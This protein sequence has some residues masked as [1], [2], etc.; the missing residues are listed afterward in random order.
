MSPR[1]YPGKPLLQIAGKPMIQHVYEQVSRANLDEIIVA[2]DDYRVLEVVKNFNG[3]VIMTRK[4]S[5][6]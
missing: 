5:F 4:K 6:K 1:D 2:C 3:K